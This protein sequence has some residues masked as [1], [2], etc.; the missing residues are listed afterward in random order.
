MIAGD[1][2]RT[3]PCHFCDRYR[4]ADFTTRRIDH[5]EQPDECEILFQ[6]GLD[7]FGNLIDQ[8]EC[9]SEDSHS[10]FGESLVGGLNPDFVTVVHFF[11]FSAHPHITRQIKQSIHTALR[12]GNVTMIVH[13][14]ASQHFGI[15]LPQVMDGSHPLTF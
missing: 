10:P 7:D 15:V 11:G 12:E 4:F 3:N 14:Q 6:V 2:H 13:I 8:T 9:H 5:S 1:H